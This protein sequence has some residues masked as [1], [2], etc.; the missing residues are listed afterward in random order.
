[1][2]LGSYLR[3]TRTELKHVNWPTR[4]QTV[5]FTVL[6]IGLSLIVAGILGVFDLSYDYLLRE[7]I[8]DTKVIS[9]SPSV[10][11]STDTGAVDVTT[12]PIFDDEPVTNGQ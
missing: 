8:L 3:E 6:V 1:M 5:N 9:P 12:E 2:G 7:F 4:K 11:T 10:E